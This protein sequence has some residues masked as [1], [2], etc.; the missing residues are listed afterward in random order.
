MGWTSPKL[1]SGAYDVSLCTV[2]ST[3]TA[4]AV[5]GV[6]TISSGTCWMTMSTT[7]WC[8]PAPCRLSRASG[9]R[10]LM[11]LPLTTRSVAASLQ[12]MSRSV[13][14]VWSVWLLTS[15]ALFTCRVL[16]PNQRC[17]CTEGSCYTFTIYSIHV[18]KTCWM[19]SL[20]CCTV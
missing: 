4:C 11:S 7:F 19:A 6:R 1:S 5:S 8:Q 17:Q 15:E 9:R 20:I 12:F 18:L 2:F 13:N 16:T 14:W 10:V 3:F